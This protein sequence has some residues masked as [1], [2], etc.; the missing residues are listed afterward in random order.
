MNI[1]YCVKNIDTY[2]LIEAHLTGPVRR[3]DWI[4]FFDKISHDVKKTEQLYMLINEN[5]YE[6]DIDYNTAN[7]LLQRAS[8]SSIKKFIISFSTADPLKKQME[9]LFSAM[10]TIANVPFA[11]SYRLSITEARNVIKKLCMSCYAKVKK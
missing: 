11:I 3:G 9:K 5:K 6:S 1:T 8:K 7:T 2:T 4:V 10:A